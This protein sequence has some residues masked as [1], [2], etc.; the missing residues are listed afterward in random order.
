MSNNGINDNANKYTTKDLE[1]T[2][3]NIVCSYINIKLDELTYKIIASFSLGV[4]F[5]PV[6]IGLFFIIIFCLFLEF[7]YAAIVKKITIAYIEIRLLLI[8]AY[9][10]G[11]ILGRTVIGDT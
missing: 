7:I 11:F 8:S 5:A 1:N 9:I 3:Y 6:G 2:I 4:I 10:L